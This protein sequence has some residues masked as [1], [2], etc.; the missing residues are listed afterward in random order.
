MK[1]MVINPVTLNYEQVDETGWERFGRI[2]CTVILLLLLVAVNVWVY[3]RIFDDLPRT[4]VLKKANI[5]WQARM[6]VMNRQ[7]DNYEQVLLGLEERDDRVYRSIYGL[8]TVSEERKKSGMANSERY[9]ELEQGGASVLLK[10]TARRLDT[11]SKRVCIQSKA[12]DDIRMMADQSGDMLSCV[13]SL[14]PLCPDHSAVRL[15]SSFGFRRDP[16]YGGTEYHSGQDFAT[17]KGTPVYATGDGVVVEAEVRYRGYGNEILLDHGYG[18]K[19]RYAHLNTIEVVPG[20]KVRRGERIGSVGNTGKSTG[21]HLHYEVIYRGKRVNP[22]NYM[23][24]NM[25]QSE[26][27]A[28]IRTRFEESAHDKKRSTSEI[29]RQRRGRDE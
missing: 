29:M 23:D 14:P 25:P 4:A 8:N 13:P 22:M 2:A 21:A 28:L 18:Y 7:L 26:F 3:V 20:M 11:L 9:G 6:E 19:T 12:L 10:R 5:Q 27:F 1:R 15:S 24:F 16:V 17:K